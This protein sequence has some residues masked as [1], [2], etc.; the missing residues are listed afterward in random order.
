MHT[1]AGPTAPITVTLPNSLADFVGKQY[2]IDCT[3]GTIPHVAQITAGIIPTTW[4][5]IHRRATC[6]PGP[7][8]GFTFV[9]LSPGQVRVVASTNVVFS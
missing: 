7:V 4:D 8:S 9:V 1:L 6:S 2:H 3:T 5:G